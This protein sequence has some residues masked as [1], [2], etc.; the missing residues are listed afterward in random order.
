[1]KT[2]TCTA[3][4]SLRCVPQFLIHKNVDLD[5]RDNDGVTALHLA[6]AQR[7]ERAVVQAL[8]EAGARPNSTDM[9]DEMPL[10]WAASSGRTEVRWGAEQQATFRE[11]SHCPPKPPS[12]FLLTLIGRACLRAWAGHA[13]AD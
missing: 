11:S 5:A 3:A 8:L 4:S 2:L 6:S 9:N 13:H 7:D 10:H 12:P 1:M